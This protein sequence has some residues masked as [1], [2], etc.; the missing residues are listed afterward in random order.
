[1]YTDLLYMRVAYATLLAIF[2]F[3]G[4]LRCLDLWKPL[5]GKNADELYPARRIV[6]C[7]YF[8]VI[9]LLPCALHPQSTDAQLLAHCFWILFVPA[10]TTLG[11][12]RFF[13]GDSLH[14]WLRIALVGGVP[15][16]FML[17][18][19]CIALA[20]GDILMPHK[21]IIIHTVV[22]LGALLTAYEIHVMIWLWHIM[23]GTDAASRA[24]DKLFPKK[25]ASGM[26]FVSSAVLVAA[27][28]EFRIG[29]ITSN[30]VLVGIITV[31]GLGILFVILHPQRVEKGTGEPGNAEDAT[32]MV[33]VSPNVCDVHIAMPSGT[34]GEPADACTCCPEDEDAADRARPEAVRPKEKKYALSDAQL[35]SM[36]RLIRKFVEGSK[37]Y[38]NPKLTQKTLEKKLEVNHFYLSEVFTRRFG[39]FNLYL[40]TLRM[41]QAIRYAAEHPE[42]KQMEVL[43]HSGFG[44]DN[45]YYRAKKIY[46]MK[47]SASNDTESGKPVD[48][49]DL[50]E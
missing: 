44:S 9:L 25:F 10:A 7:L 31:V 18:L 15:L 43:H 5:C 6:S 47:N 40:N 50:R 8:S 33:A 32:A 2:M 46:G 48:T 37:L 41:E 36:E 38:L 19:S 11:Y 30:T 27:W 4:V 29:G 14:K 20:G 22:V 13:Y 24:A 39:S 21:K 28:V 35:D 12:K 26:L 17:A 42:A 23:S 16:A 3:C 45:S 34:D 49:K 1:M